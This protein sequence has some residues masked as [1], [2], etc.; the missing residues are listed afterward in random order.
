MI[1]PCMPVRLATDEC[2]APA[3]LHHASANAL[4]NETLFILPQKGANSD[5]H[6]FNRL[7]RE[8]SLEKCIC[9][10]SWRKD[11]R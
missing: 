8:K 10:V 7:Q 9:S 4:K 3:V 1:D 2:R 11:P 5:L 6:F